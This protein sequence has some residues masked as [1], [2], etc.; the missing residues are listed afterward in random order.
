LT[1]EGEM[2]VPATNPAASPSAAAASSAANA[3]A[4]SVAS[5]T[6][7]GAAQTGAEDKTVISSDFTTFLKMLTTQMQNQDPLDPMDSTDFAVQLATF[8]GVEQQVKT[9]DILQGVK[10]QLGAM[11]MSDLAGWVGMEARA[12]APA[13]FSGSPV[14]LQ[15]NPA[16]GAEQTYVVVKD[17]QGNVVDR[18]QIPVSDQSVTWAGVTA[19][20]DPYPPGLYSFYLESDSQG[21]VLSLDQMPVYNEVVEARSE[22][23]DTILVLSG[24]TEVSAADVDALRA[25]QVASPSDVGSGQTP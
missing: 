11:S 1:K 2:N 20:G 5:D 16:S 19:T 10:D 21:Q 3:N 9:N 12:V 8:S 4:D 17:D 25:P 23:G 6:A 14:T 13:W 22:N 18:E 7:S 24:G 15:P